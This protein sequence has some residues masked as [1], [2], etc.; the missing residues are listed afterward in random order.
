MSRPDKLTQ[1]DAMDRALSCLGIALEAAGHMLPSNEA[2]AE[3]S[4]PSLTIGELPESLRD[5][6]AVLARGRQVE[7]QGLRLVRH[8]EPTLQTTD[9]FAMAARNGGT[10]SDEVLTRMRDDRAN[11]IAARKR[12]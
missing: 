7:E 1:F 12:K 10:L 4:K 9:D 3:A 11:A 5:P 8:R 2:M 6:M